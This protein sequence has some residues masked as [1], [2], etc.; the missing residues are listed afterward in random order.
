MNLNWVED[1][2]L[3]PL[4]YPAAFILKAVR[5]MGVHRLPLC[6][7]ALMNVGVFPI[8]NHFYEPQFDHRYPNPDFSQDRNL[9]GIGWNVSGQLEMLERLTFFNG[10]ADIQ[11]DRP[12][13]P[14]PLKFY[15]R[16]DSFGPGDAEYW[17]AL[18]RAI[19]PARI[20]E[21]GSGNSTLMAMS[22]IRHP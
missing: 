14:D 22:A 18:I 7:S 2:I 21:I 3:M 6:K 17:Y 8:K 20:I 9:P 15:M 10:L 12:S 1:I 16:N 11:Q 19:K 4:V 5:R 13:P